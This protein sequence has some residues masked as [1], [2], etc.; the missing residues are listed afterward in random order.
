MQ[1]KPNNGDNAFPGRQAGFG[2]SQA[3]AI[4][5]LIL[6]SV[7]IIGCFAQPVLAENHGGEYRL[8]MV[9]SWTGVSDFLVLDLDGDGY[10][11]L[12]RLYD[13]RRTY[14]AN[15]F[16]R[17]RVVGPA[18]YQGNSLFDI[19]AVSPVD[20]DSLP[21]SEIALVKKDT[22]GDSLWVE[23][24][25]GKEKRL[26]CKTKAVGGENRS[27]VID[28]WD[29]G[30]NHCYA[31]DLDDDG[32]KEIIL[33]V[34]VAFDL[35]PRGI[36][37]YEY[38]SGNLKW[39]FPLAGNPMPLSF[40][41]ANKDGFREIYIKTAACCNGAVVGDRADTSSYIHV[42]D[43]LGHLVWSRLMGDVFDLETREPLVCDCDNDGTVEI[44]YTKI[45]NTEEFDQQ[46][47]AL[48][49][50]RAIDDFF[51]EQRQFGADQEYSRIL[52]INSENH[53]HELILLDKNMCL[54]DPAGLNIVKYGETKGGN[55]LD[56]GN[57]YNKDSRQEII[58]TANDSLY[59]T[60]DSLNIIGSLGQDVPGS[61]S[62]TGFV[63]TPFGNHYILTIHVVPTALATS[64]LEVYSVDYV[65]IVRKWEPRLS[66][67]MVFAA[68]VVGLVLGALYCY[69]YLRSRR[70]SPP[71]KTIDTVQYNN[72]L[73]ALVNFNHGQMAGKNLN[74]LIFLFSNLPDS[75]EKL[76]EIKPNLKS[77]VEAYQ[78]F[79]STQLMSIVNNS[80]R[81][82]SIKDPVDDLAGELRKVSA[83]L[84]H[85][86]VME[87]DVEQSAM[88]KK[89]VPETIE[90]IQEAIRQIRKFLQAHFSANILRVIPEVLAAVA[91]QF[92]Q[93]GIGFSEIKSTG[94]T[95][96][97]VFFDETTLA[98]IF[99]ELL[100]NAS[101][102]MIES[103]I[104][105]LRL[106]VEFDGSEAIIRLSD[107]GHGLR[108]EQ[109]DQLFRRDYSTHGN[110]RGYGLY[111]ARQE[112]ERFGGHIKLYNNDG[113]PGATVELV[114]KR[115]NG[116]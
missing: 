57:F 102:A 49:K 25:M 103:D 55:I 28:H 62:K 96:H 52:N 45:I 17:N 31:E 76:G 110:D 70:P 93:R 35:Y 58:V 65:P 19:I 72:L 36:Y 66:F 113:R 14:H 88:L 21:G 10:D 20:I 15:R 78:S 107:T 47:W 86:Q 99:E 33:P 6:L 51:I 100:S 34:A 48:Q 23:I 12:F 111:H 115:V 1:N 90:H 91:G 116:E 108:A 104:K 74:R 18:L 81:L 112:V 26:L 59:I 43:H 69:M 27:K 7:G 106:E 77:A 95:N 40:A 67:W 75:P 61:F 97:L 4:L 3:K 87:L 38:P 30:A 80:E 84:D 53:G 32:S 79:T 5:Y 101:D 71:S 16:V 109:H 114:L 24:Y 98:A 2:P 46:V 29:G 60:D 44:Y 73:T 82:T 39:W 22:D 92:Q 8:S 89:T 13:G 11:E 85:L 42:V 9:E 41:D 54:I 50:R 94:G 83:Y 56:I 64:A 37:V 68:F 105:D 63:D